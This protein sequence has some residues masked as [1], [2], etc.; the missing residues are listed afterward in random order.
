[1]MI[2]ADSSVSFSAIAKFIGLPCGRHHCRPKMEK[3]AVRGS[4]RRVSEISD[5]C[6]YASR[7]GDV[8]VP[9]RQ[10]H[11]QHALRSNTFITSTNYI[12]RAG[13]VKRSHEVNGEKI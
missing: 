10:Q 6:S 5:G 13:D 12:A 4:R 7:S 8:C 1:M 2:S 11:I 9:V 3:P